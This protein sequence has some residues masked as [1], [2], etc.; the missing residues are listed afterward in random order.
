MLWSECHKKAASAGMVLQRA[1]AKP[2]RPIAA[3]TAS[4]EVLATLAHAASLLGVPLF[5]LDPKLPEAVITHLLTQAGVELIV[6]GSDSANLK[7][8]PRGMVADDEAGTPPSHRRGGDIA[9]LVAT[10]GSCGQ[11]KSVMLSALNLRAAALASA[12]STPL[13]PGDRWLA[14]LPLFHIGGFSILT[15]C[16]LAGAEAVLHQGFDPARVLRDLA[17]AR[18]THLSLVPAM[19]AALIEI[20]EAPPP[21]ALRHVLI[22]GAALHPDLAEL[23]VGLGWPV[24]PSYGMS[25]TSSQVATLAKLPRPWRAGLVG[26]PLP[27]ASIELGLGGTLKVRGPMV[28]LGYANPSMEPGL[29]LEDGW[30][31][32]NDLAKITESGELIVLGRADDV[33]VSG[34]VKVQP[35]IVEDLLTRCPGVDSVMVSGRKNP[36]WG[37]IVVA[38]YT[39]TASEGQLIDWCRVNLPP[40]LRPRD[41]IRIHVLPALTSGKPDRAALRRIVARSNPESAT[42]RQDHYPGLNRGA[43]SDIPS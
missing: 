25:E 30:F 15:R 8:E 42:G 33:I 21:P 16:A 6:S 18:I 38:V 11:P 9:L 31:Q 27:G 35:W 26:R 36:V 41:A 39:G 34:G 40:G 3:I 28:M 13:R 24:Q 4:A 20:T 12:A 17:L 14:C 37:E 5:P 22:G 7:V 29:G 2:G 19:L 23:A 43:P 10:S 1:G 32:T